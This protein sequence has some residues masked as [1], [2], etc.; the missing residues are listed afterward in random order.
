MEIKSK[1]TFSPTEQLLLS[2]GS[3]DTLKA[4]NMYGAKCVKDITTKKAKEIELYNVAAKYGY[5]TI[6]LTDLLKFIRIYGMEMIS[7]KEYE[8]EIPHDISL[9]IK[10]FIDHVGMSDFHSMEHFFLLDR[11]GNAVA[12]IS[13]MNQHNRTEDLF[14]V[15][16]NY[17]ERRI[18]LWNRIMSLLT[19]LPELS[20]FW[21]IQA[22]TIVLF[23][24]LAWLFDGVGM[25]AYFSIYIVIGILTSILFIQGTWADKVETNN[26]MYRASTTGKVRESAH[27]LGLRNKAGLYEHNTDMHYNGYHLMIKIALFVSALYIMNFMMPTLTMN[28][29]KSEKYFTCNTHIYGHSVRGKYYIAEFKSL[30]DLCE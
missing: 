4:L 30:G 6:L 24:V 22:I 28:P 26:L 3:D 27:R 23:T 17:F 19:Y 2:D 13:R 11:K 1:V 25:A 16:S 12:G 18:G 29:T 9:S 10:K 20:A 7:P 8:K 15:H 21:A 14:I 5:N